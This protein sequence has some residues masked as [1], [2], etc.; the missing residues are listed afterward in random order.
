MEDVSD[1]QWH[2]CTITFWEKAKFPGLQIGYKFI[3]RSDPE[4]GLKYGSSPPA[5]AESPLGRGLCFSSDTSHA[6]LSLG[7]KQRL[8]DEPGDRRRI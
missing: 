8:R 7:P 3:V 6:G 1:P 2:L 4:L 5:R